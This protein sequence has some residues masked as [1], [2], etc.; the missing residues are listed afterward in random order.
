MTF[1]ISNLIKSL[2]LSAALLAAGCASFPGNELPKR[3]YDALDPVRPKAVVD[4]AVTFSGQGGQRMYSAS[5]LLSERVKAVFDKSGIFSKH[6]LDGKGAPVQLSIKL[7]NKGDQRT[8][9]LLGIVAGLS[10]TVIPVYV[11]D[12]YELTVDVNAGD[13]VIKSYICKDHMTTW[14]QLF[15]IF[16]FPSHKPVDVWREVVD[17]ML[18][19]FLHNAVADGVFNGA[20]NQISGTQ[21]EGVAVS[22]AGGN[23]YD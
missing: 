14:F 15:L 20:D 7:D 18:L 9:K 23:G 3:G 19:N 21:G 22:A 10:L 8:A 2:L 5:Y 16:A 6:T 13:K 12:N 1:R 17:N 11:T 4:Y